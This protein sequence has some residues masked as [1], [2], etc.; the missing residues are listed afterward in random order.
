VELRLGDAEALGEADASYDVVLSSFA[1]MF[2]PR[3][4]QVA[5]EVAR[6]CRPG[7]TIAY[8]AWEEGLATN[9]LVSY[10]PPGPVFAGDP[11]RWADPVHVQTLFADQP[12]VWSFTRRALPVAFPSLAA[13]EEFVF[14]NSG[15]MMAARDALQELG[16]WDQAIAALRRAFEAANR[17]ADGSY[18]GEWPY[19][20][21][22]ARMG[23][24]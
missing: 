1:M 8:T 17:A 12:T 20:L 9:A 3:H 15:P 6:V 10:L 21:G 2:A 18:R 13:L 11:N 23:A 5:D 14:T 24:E 22:M 4:Q 19:L 16:V 7:G